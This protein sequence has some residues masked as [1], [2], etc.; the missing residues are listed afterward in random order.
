VSGAEQA[1]ENAEE[2]GLAC[3]VFTEENVAAAGLEIERDLAEGGKA[4]E[5]LG[6]LIE[7][8]AEG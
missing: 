2:R 6:H 3:A 1:S 5:E 4:A 8:G 7:S